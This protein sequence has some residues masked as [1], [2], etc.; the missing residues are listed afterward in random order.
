MKQEKKLGPEEQKAAHVRHLK[1]ILIMF[2]KKAVFNSMVGAE[3]VAAYKALEA[4]KEVIEDLEKQP[5]PAVEQ[6]TT[7]VVQVEEPKK[8]KRAKREKV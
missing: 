7:E 2:N 6:P 1:N 4:V 8:N 3:I 5:A